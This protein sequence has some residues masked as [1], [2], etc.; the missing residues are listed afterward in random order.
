[1]FK[2]LVN[3]PYVLNV[4]V[5]SDIFKFHFNGNSPSKFTSVEDD[6]SIHLN[7]NSG[8]LRHSELL[9]RSL[10]SPGTGLSSRL[11]F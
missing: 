8:P 6:E 1:M 2:H 10:P 3:A 7:P 9:I 5:P 4:L 11:P